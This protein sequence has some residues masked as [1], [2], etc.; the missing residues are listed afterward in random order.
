MINA[1]C[2]TVDGIHIGVCGSLNRVQWFK[3][4]WGEGFTR[5]IGFGCT[6]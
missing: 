4:N 6:Y 1:M 2:V 5:D 3:M